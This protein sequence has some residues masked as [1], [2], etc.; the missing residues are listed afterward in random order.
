MT[1]YTLTLTPENGPRTEQHGLTRE[2]AL[3]A[4]TDLMY[5][6][7]TYGETSERRTEPTDAHEGRLAA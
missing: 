2:Q 4:L 6:G 3:W 1:T 7:D 5:G